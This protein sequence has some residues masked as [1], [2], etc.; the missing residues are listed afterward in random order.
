MQRRLSAEHKTYS[1]VREE[2]RAEAAGN[3][4]ENTDATI[5]E[6]SEQLGYSDQSHFTRAFRCWAAV[7]PTEFR[8]QRRRAESL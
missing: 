3:L 7:S 2:T 1:E 5:F 8:A 4:L 6:T